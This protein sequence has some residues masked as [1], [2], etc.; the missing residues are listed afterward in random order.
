M[1]VDCYLC[2]D[3]GEIFYGNGDDFD[4]EYCQCQ[5]GYEKYE[6]HELYLLDSINDPWAIGELFTTPEAR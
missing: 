3:R 6:Q 2:Y 1:K 4:F 5:A